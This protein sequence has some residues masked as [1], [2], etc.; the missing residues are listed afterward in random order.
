[1]ADVDDGGRPNGPPSS[2]E[3]LIDPERLRDSI[4]RTAGRLSEF[5]R[6]GVIRPRVSTRIVHDVSAEAT[7]EQYGRTF[8]FASDEPAGRGGT[9]SAPT[10]IRYFLSAIGFCLDVWLAK[11]AAVVDCEI[12]DVA[13]MIEARLDMRIEY[14]LEPSGAPQYLLADVRVSSPSP[15]DRVLAMADEAFRRCPLVHAIRLPVY[16]RVTHD[17]R[18]IRDELPSEAGEADATLDS[19]AREQAQA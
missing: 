2:G 8:T 16:Q 9:G 6:G 14:D 12:R 11:G 17:G 3:P 19:A 5:T 15:S 18:V 4:E 1:M 13:L 7:F 10:S